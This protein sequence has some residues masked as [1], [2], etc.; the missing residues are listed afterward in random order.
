MVIIVT[1]NV[2]LFNINMNLILMIGTG[3]S[4][5][6]SVIIVTD[7]VILLNINM[8]LILMIG[9]GNSELLVLGRLY[10]CTN[11]RPK[12]TEK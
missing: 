4:E 11:T 5:L 3:N 1:D 2:V 10:I 6:L 12:I 7:N 9:T 8:K